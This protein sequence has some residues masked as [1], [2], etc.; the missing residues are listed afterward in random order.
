M[1][2]FAI[3]RA[4]ETKLMAITNDAVI[5]AMVSYCNELQS[6]AT[7]TIKVKYIQQ[8]ELVKHLRAQPSSC[9]FD[10][11]RNSITVR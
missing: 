11:N 9:L 1:N 7:R 6:D 10:P 8:F 3:V 5:R 4:V 2:A